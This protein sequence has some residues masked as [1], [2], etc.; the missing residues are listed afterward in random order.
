M[1]YVHDTQKMWRLW[2]P[3]RK[4]I[5]DSSSVVF[6]ENEM[7]PGTQTIPQPAQQPVL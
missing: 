2:D 3:M 5:F 7:P 1:G 6:A 4:H